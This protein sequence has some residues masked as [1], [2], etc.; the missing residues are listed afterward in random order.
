MSPFQY[1]ALG[2]R[3]RRAL[4]PSAVAPILSEWIRSAATLTIG[5][6]AKNVSVADSSTLPVNLASCH[7]ASAAHPASSNRA[8]VS[9]AFLRSFLA[10]VRSFVRSLSA[11]PGSCDRTA[12]FTPLRIWALATISDT[13]AF[14]GF[15]VANTLS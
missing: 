13:S 15:N 1:R 4:G 5:S 9:A 8:H 6:S 2:E 3:A 14:R 11:V 7:S 12:L 10:F